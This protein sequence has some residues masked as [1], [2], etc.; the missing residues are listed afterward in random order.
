MKIGDRV[1]P[2][3]HRYV[4]RSGCGVYPYAIVKSIDPFVLVSEDGDMTWRAT[5]KQEDFCK[6]PTEPEEITW[7]TGM[8]LPHEFS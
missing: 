8:D 5:V 4:L 1:I 7:G 2:K 6:Q 3:A